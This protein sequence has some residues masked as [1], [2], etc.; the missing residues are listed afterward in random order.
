MDIK[1]PN[2]PKDYE[3]A[4]KPL[5]KNSDA[6]KIPPRTEIKPFAGLPASTQPKSL[7]MEK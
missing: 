3:S 5:P 1:E 7:K 6:N 2:F 4:R